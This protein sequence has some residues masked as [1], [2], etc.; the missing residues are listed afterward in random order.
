[1]PKKVKLKKGT[2]IRKRIV[3]MRTSIATATNPVMDRHVALRDAA[4]QGWSA[5][6]KPEIVKVTKNVTKIGSPMVWQIIMYAPV[7]Q[8][9]TSGHTVYRMLSDAR[10]GNMATRI[11]HAF[12]KPGYEAKTAPN[13]FGQFGAGGVVLWVSKY[14]STS[15]IVAR[16]WEELIAQMLNPEFEAALLAG[17]RNGLRG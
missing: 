14:Y 11:R 10:D 5:T 6:N 12:L 4:T 8:G 17:G 15:G 13:R 7:A 16:N 2:T 9:S 3:K 1:M